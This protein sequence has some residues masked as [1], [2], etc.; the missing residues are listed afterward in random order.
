MTNDQTAAVAQAAAAADTHNDANTRNA[1]DT[2]NADTHNSADT[3]TRKAK[4]TI[5]LMT[6]LPASGKST[7]A[8]ELMAAADGR[9]RRV[10]LDEL[11]KMLDDNHGD[12]RLTYVHEET[13]LQVQDAAVLAAVNAGFDIVVDNT[14]LV[15][16]IPNRLK[17]L[18]NGR[19]VFEVHDFTDVDV[20]ECIRRDALRENPVG[21]EHIRRMALRLASTRSSGWRLTAALL[22]TVQQVETYVADPALPTAVL[23]DIDGTLADHDG[24]RGP[25]DLERCEVDRLIPS[26]ADALV[27]FA[28]RGDRV[29][30]V[31]GRGED[32]RAHTERWLAAHGVTYDELWM[33]K[34][35]DTRGDDVVKG[36]LFDA[37]IRLRFNVRVVL[38]DRDRVVALWRR[39][40]L[41]C[42]QVNYGDF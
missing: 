40:G 27:A 3:N 39:L 31:S 24:L 5:H 26:T 23:C 9:M 35:G 38:D 22:N 37:H 6:G 15:S 4:P 29:V 12:K 2:H 13:V 25:Y 33:R 14:H 30:L 17:R 21:E 28:A 11:R 34:A 10:S 41:P 7:R 20:E 1:A 19:A 8:R 32:V 16:R 36:E 42:W 18:V